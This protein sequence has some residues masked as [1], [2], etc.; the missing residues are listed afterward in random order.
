MNWIFL[1]TEVIIELSTDGQNFIAAEGMRPDLLTLREP[2]AIDYNHVR[3]NAKARYIRIIAKNRGV[4]PE[5][6][7]GAG[8]KAWLFLDEVMIN[9][10]VD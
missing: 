8:K 1:P 3:I 2:V 6:H 4:C 5:G 10:P 9:Q 7:P